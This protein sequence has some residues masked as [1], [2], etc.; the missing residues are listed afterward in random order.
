MKEEIIDLME[1]EEGRKT[2][3]QMCKHSTLLIYWALKHILPR[4]IAKSI[5]SRNKRWILTDK[6]LFN[7]LQL[8]T[9]TTSTTTTT[10]TPT[11]TTS[12]TKTTTT[13]STFSEQKKRKFE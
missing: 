8:S 6:N 7:L 9:T 3:E 1:D 10:T 13:T 2:G 4:D 11:T 12:T 5:S